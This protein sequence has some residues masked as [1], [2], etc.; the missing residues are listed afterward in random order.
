LQ[1]GKMLTRQL[2]P[3]VVQMATPA[4]ALRALM[5]GPWVD[6]RRQ[7]RTWGVPGLG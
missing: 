1:I 7:L 5:R 6:A 2:P 3:E 4:V